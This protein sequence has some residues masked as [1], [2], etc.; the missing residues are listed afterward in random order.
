[1]VPACTG[2]AVVARGCV[3]SL[4]LGFVLISFSTPAGDSLGLASELGSVEPDRWVLVGD[5]ILREGAP[6]GPQICS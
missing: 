1:M 2:F 6:K 5:A 4:M 3:E